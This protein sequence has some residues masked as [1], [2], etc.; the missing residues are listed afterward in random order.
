MCLPSRSLGG[1]RRASDKIGVVGVDVGGLYGD[2]RL[3][4]LGSRAETLAKELRDDL[5]ELSV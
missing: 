2:E 3:N 1:R 4:V 5:D